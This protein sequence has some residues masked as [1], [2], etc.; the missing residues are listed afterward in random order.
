M[1]EYLVHNLY[2]AVESNKIRFDVNNFEDFIETCSLFIC[3]V[4]SLASLLGL[5]SV[6]L[7]HSYEVK[8]FI[9]QNWNV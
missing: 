1:C 2:D 7:M 4:I 5:V 9:Q 6:A 8:H 3:P